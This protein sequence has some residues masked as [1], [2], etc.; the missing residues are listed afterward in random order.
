MGKQ[1]FWMKEKIHMEW[2]IFDKKSMH[3]FL[4]WEILLVFGMWKCEQVKRILEISTL[5]KEKELGTVKM[6][7]RWENC[8]CETVYL[9][10]LNCDCMCMEYKL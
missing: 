9:F 7:S 3:I 6:Q 1:I 4:M 2:I 5:K 8:I 10:V